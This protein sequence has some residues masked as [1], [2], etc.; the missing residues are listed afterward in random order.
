[1]DEFDHEDNMY[2][3]TFNS[4]QWWYNA[5]ALQAAGGTA[6]AAAAA[7]L[8]AR[9]ATEVARVAALNKAKRDAKKRKAEEARKRRA[10][11]ARKEAQQREELR[12][13]G[14]AAVSALHLKQGAQRATSRFRWQCLPQK[15][16]DAPPAEIVDDGAK[17]VCVFLKK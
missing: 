9:R 10:L 11:V 17:C 5:A 16:N 8:A 13:A 1:V 4:V 14:K 7:A 3:V 15:S 12:R 2:A 6:G